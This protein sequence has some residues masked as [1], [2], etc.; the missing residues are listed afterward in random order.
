MSRYL[1]P[2]N[3]DEALRELAEDRWTVLAGGTDHFPARAIHDRDEDILD[4]TALEALKGIE[5][6]AAGLRI[7]AAATWR[8]VIDADLPPACDGLKAAARE[9]GGAQIQNRGTVGG[10][11]CNA[12]P[13]A[14]GVP[15]LLSLD[16][17]VELA[18]IGGT[19]RLPLDR[20]VLGNRKT[21][22]AP[23]ELL[24]A[25]HLPQTALEGTG[26]FLKL[27]ARRYLVISI[28]MVAGTMRLAPDGTV[29]AARMAVGACSAAALRLEALENALVGLSPRGAADRLDDS[30][31]AA[32]API[33]DVRGD[34]PY[35]LDTARILVR[36]C[37]TD[38][39]EAA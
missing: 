29:A 8:A 9:I 32:L 11:L 7:G 23:G 19:R 6:T 28:V 38:L 26:R 16:A 2:R 36:R 4:I 31:L 25:I 15:A 1:R 3:L 30:H 33:A 35:R 21:A 39:A 17:E 12:S 24:T 14:D 20:F 37:L 34:A 27:G 18:S 10:N 22:L 13:A 5:R